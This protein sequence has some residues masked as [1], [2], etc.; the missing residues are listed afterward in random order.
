MAALECS[1][2]QKYAYSIPEGVLQTYEV[3]E[4]KRLPVEREPDLG[5]PCDQCPKGGPENEE[6]LRLSDRNFEAYQLYEKLRATHGTYRLHPK[7][8]GCPTF[9]E[10]MAL[11]ERTIERAKIEVNNRHVREAEERAKAD[12]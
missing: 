3:E 7:V 10:N 12:H 4:G 9:A 5:P 2:C 1:E 8:A 6:R 11:I